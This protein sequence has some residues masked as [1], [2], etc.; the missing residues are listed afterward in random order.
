MGKKRKLHPLGVLDGNK[1]VFSV[2]ESDDPA[3]IGQ[4][5]ICQK[6]KPG[7]NWGQESGTLS[8][9]GEHVTFTAHD[10]GETLVVEDRTKKSKGPSKVANPAYRSGWDRVFGDDGLKN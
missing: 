2:C 1:D 4:I 6:Q 5:T 7:Q 3:E 9:D 8:D 10:S